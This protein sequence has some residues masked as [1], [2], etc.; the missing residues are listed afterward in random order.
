MIL[1]TGENGAG[2]TTLLRILATALRPSRGSLELF[3][4]DAVTHQASLRGRLALM[5]HHHHLYEALSAR[6]NLELTVRLS[7]RGAL[8]AIPG[9]LDEVGLA[10]VASLPVGTYSA[11]MKRRLGL[12]KLLLT[13][14]ELALLDEP[15]GQLDPGGVQ[16]MEDV[17][18]RLKAR[19]ATVVMSTHDIARGEALCDAHLRLAG[20][21]QQGPV[22]PV[23]G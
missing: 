4:M 19:G 15:F 9:H 8:T 16:L 23:A 11:G 21:R 5:T 7:G 18:R 20:G 22:Q 12:A 17:V 3:G 6:E 10:A 14:P 1:L 13:A 2:K